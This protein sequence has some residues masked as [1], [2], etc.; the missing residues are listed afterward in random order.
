MAM[1][2]LSPVPKLLLSTTPSS[3]LSSDKNFFFVDFVGLYC[4]SKR[5]R[6]RLRGDSSSST[7]RA[8]PLSRLSSV[9]AVIDLERVHDKDLASPSYLK[10]QVAN[11]EDILSERGACGVGFIANLDNI[12]SHGVVKDALIALGCM[13]HR[14]GCG[15]D[16]DSGDGSG[17]MSSIPWD[18]F[19]VWAKEQ[20]LAPFDKLH[21][22]VG[23]IFLPQED[24]FLQEAKQVIENIFAKEGLEVLGWR[25]VPVNAPIVGKNARETMPNI[26]QVFVKIAKDDS[27]DDIER[28]LYICRK[29][30][31]RAVA[32]E[33]WGTELYF[34]SLSNQT[35]VYK[36]MLRSE[37]LG[38]FY[39]DLQNEL[40]TS[41][42]AIY[43]RRYSTNTSPRWPLA[44]P[45]RFLGHNG[46]I[47]TIQGNLNW[48]QSR[49][50]SLKSSVWNGRENEI[51]PFG[52]PRG[53]DSA[54]LDSAAEILIRSGRT[55][56]E[57][58]MILV[59]EA[60]KNHPTLS[61]K[62][63]EVLDFY[64][65]YKGQM[66]A[67]DGPALLLF[68]DGKTVGACLDRNGL[69]PA[70]YWRTSDNF[71]YVASEVGVVPVDE[72]KV[73]MKG[74]LGPG[75]M[76]AAD[77]VNGQV[78]ENTE[79]KKRVSSLN[80]YG[81]W[82]KENL[83]FLKPVNFKSSTVMENEEILRTQQAF[84]YSSE[85]V[86]M[87]IESMA[88]QGKEP[89]FCMGDDIPLAGLS[90]RP[91]MLY[92]YF[93]QRFAQV[94]NPAIDP[95]REG[96]VMS[97]EVNIGKRGNI[98]ELGPENA[99]QVILSNPVLNEGGI[100]ELMKDTYL[101]PKV[102]STFFDIRKGVE[103]SL[104]KAL[105]YLCEAADDA[106]RS[107]S[108]LLILSD[109]TD[110][111]EPTRPAIPIMLAVGAV[112]QHLIQNG[113][114]M[115]ASIV[116]DTA[117]CFSTHQFACLIG[118]GA[119][120][121]CP[122]LALE[123]CRQWR[124]SNKTVAL[125]R[126]GKIPTV[127]IEQ[128]QKN[129]TKAVNAGLLKI[130]SKMGI[131]LLSSYCG[132][133]IF[134][135]YG[136]GQDVVDLAFTGSV[137]KIS[138]LTFDELARET[139]SFWVKAFSEDTTKRLE[140][141]GFIQFRP[142]GEYHSNNPEMSKLLHK[143]VREKSETAYAVYQQHLANRPVNVLRDLL[144][145]KSDRAPIPVGKV[146]PAVSI[147]QRF[148][149]G[150]M[151]LGAISRETHEAIAIAMNRIGGKSNSG[152]GG[153][154]V[155]AGLLKILSKM[156]ISL[157]SS[158]CGAQ[159]FE[160][161]G[162]GKEVVDLAFTGSVSKISG[163][164]FDEL[165]RETLSFWVKAFSE[166][167]TK[168]L[169]NFGFIQ[170]R[171]GGEYHS[172]NPEMSKLLHKAVR[173]KSETAYAVYQ[174]HLAN[175]PVNVL[176]DL[177]EFKSDRA[178]IPVGKVEPAVSIVQR[179]C[180][181]GMSLGAISRETHEAIA[182]AMNRIGGKSNSGE[183]GEDPIRWKPLTDVVDGYS[184]TLP[185]LK[186]LQNGDIATS[187]IKQVASGR[188]GVTP[189]FLVNADQLE[190]KVAQGAK[191]GEGGQLPGKKVSA[192]IARLRSSKPGVPLISPPPHHDIY[193]IEDLAQLIF[194]LH[195]I[196]PNAKV[197][198]KLVAEAGIGTVASGVAKGNADIIQISG[199]DG[200]TGASP[201][202]SIKHA[203][204]PW[205]LGL[206][207]TNQERV[208]LRVDGGLKSGVDVLMAAAM[209]ADEYGFGSLAMIA[210]GCVMARICHTNNC[211]VGV[212]SQREELRARFPGVPG[213]L[214]NYFLYVAE[215]V[216][217][218]LAQLG[219]SKLDDIIGRTE[220]LKPRDI[221]LVKTQHL[222][223]S[224][225]LSSVGVPSMSSTEIRKQE[226]HTNG[227]VL[228]DDILEDPL[229]KDA[230]ENEKV[231]DKTVKICNIDRAACGRVAG[232]IAKKY[233]DTG[234]A[235]QVN[236]TFLGSA[237]QSFG[238]FLI[239]GMNIRL[240][241]EANDYVGKGMAGGEIVVTPVDKIGFV[242]EEATIVGNTCL[243]G[244]TGGQIF[245]RG[246]AGERFAVRNSLAEA[247][248]EGTG[249]HCCEY[250]T[251]GCV[252]V[253]GKVGRNVAA[254]MTGGLAYLLDED[255]TLLPKINRE[256]VKIQ[257]VTAPAGVAAEELNRS[258]CGKNRKQQRRDDPEGMGKLVPPSEEDTPEA[259]AA[260]VRTA[261][262][263]VTFQ[264]A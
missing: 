130:L 11:L 123:T 186:G 38:L 15:A 63:P 53:S 200:G 42:F 148:C 172:N 79:V 135:I 242:P 168:R 62:Y 260:Y 90:Q 71:V 218:I 103:G 112:H 206:T 111:L 170:F 237:G 136:L 145:F 128:A 133:Q 39:L 140:N 224:Y 147:V 68:S 114:R 49:E 182:I 48:M 56:E 198:V 151:S 96:L 131:S 125:M 175:R 262:G 30:I 132:A 167:T 220:L 226:V 100:E 164:T 258:P 124:L 28:E 23:M 222:D 44:Q 219:Y 207:E 120:A 232:V 211:P 57:A 89:T 160:I 165:A 223:L 35:I 92:D 74:R 263:E 64:D 58:L 52:N 250:M 40:Y 158:Y 241:G 7:S 101:K 106:V 78:Y 177:L 152:E 143:A 2:S 184:P 129:Y 22:G 249:D 54:N 149:T 4:K 26:Q 192:Y 34:C 212:A 76:I 205:E 70:R 105:Y 9:R 77:L 244:A 197:S 73:T 178:P 195:Q 99:S 155:N 229:V 95:L 86:Q 209:G 45:M 194:D 126:N 181:G 1:K 193:S 59:P 210:T 185:H 60:Y 173:E 246:K 113:L 80:P 188:F 204:G 261:T 179:F 65:Y 240:V 81:K 110:S 32:A 41:P 18:F 231:V 259:S 191:P 91:H 67:W 208:I 46:E 174:Q 13:E 150:G 252:V 243:Y 16:N 154:A 33:T 97:L 75:M 190:I 5:T 201:I 115:S 104:Q 12:P 247:V 10:P 171:P 253:L 55:A 121:V 236:L 202:S 245:A 221:S 157:L 225:L 122:Y 251:G 183:G 8:S 19:N 162:L 61:I 234:F 138:G 119:S 176:R 47:N 31:E 230:I 141:F 189:T 203:G 14:G 29:L 257:R 137:S 196:N 109:R 17:L 216:R 169:E 239:P 139:L 227:P 159:I 146:E 98:L 217:G 215:E 51:R 27:T 180:T 134:E 233:G 37:A 163:L 20:G 156:G 199:H 94:T 153:E 69:R 24:T 118:Y 88:S 161:Y 84:G 187:A 87:V 127:T 238:C 66:E 36:G 43:H 248:V 117:Q 72:A 228:D 235:G 214:V 166:D 82:I 213:D 85:D 256:I 83:R 144:E 102:L 116:A 3:V 93:K 255:D 25:D 50:A 254:G 142:G 264:S 107:G 21:T 108:Q 6:R